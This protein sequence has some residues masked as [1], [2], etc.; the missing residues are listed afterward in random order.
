M[1]LLNRVYALC[2][3][4]NTYPNLDAIRATGARYDNGA[5]LWTLNISKHPMNNTKQRK[6]LE[7]ML[8]AL[9]ERGVQIVLYREGEEQ[10]K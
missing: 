5:R 10:S 6:K 4:G 2:M 3:M 1:V 8:T 7:A 9:E